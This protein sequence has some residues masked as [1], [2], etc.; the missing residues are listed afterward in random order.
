MQGKLCRATARV[1]RRL[2]GAKTAQVKARTETYFLLVSA[3]TDRSSTAGCSQTVQI[4]APPGL[5]ADHTKALIN[6]RD[7]A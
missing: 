3:A 4:M 5:R 2:P 7:P 1:Q 6:A